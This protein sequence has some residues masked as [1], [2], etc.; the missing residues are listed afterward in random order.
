MPTGTDRERQRDRHDHR[1][2]DRSVAELPHHHAGE[3][4]ALDRSMAGNSTCSTSSASSGFGVATNYT[5]VDSPDLN[6]NNYQLGGQFALV[7]LSDSANLVVFYE[8]YD[9]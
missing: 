4:R 6:Y 7:G 5:I 1:P 9:W 3:H 2:A 8:N